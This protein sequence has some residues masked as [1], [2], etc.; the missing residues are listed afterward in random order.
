MDYYIDEW[1]IDVTLDI[2]EDS[3]VMD[4]KHY[5]VENSASIVDLFQEH[6]MYARIFH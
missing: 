1:S 3:S 6:K 4:I 5:S 2:Q